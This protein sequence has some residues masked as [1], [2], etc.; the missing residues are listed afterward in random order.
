[1]MI[2]LA[3]NLIFSLGILSLK[4]LNKFCL[5]ASI[6]L[7]L[8]VLAL[9]YKF[10]DVLIVNAVKFVLYIYLFLDLNVIRLFFELVDLAFM[11]R[12]VA[13]LLDELYFYWDVII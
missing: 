13:R 3:Y 12:F 5:F 1:M 8:F 11:D 4:K 7:L 10:I 9:C 6:K 2:C